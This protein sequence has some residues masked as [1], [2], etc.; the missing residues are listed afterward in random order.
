M[1]LVAAAAASEVVASF[2]VAGS[3]GRTAVVVAE[4]YS[5]TQRHSVY[6][7]LMGDLCYLES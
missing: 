2:A 4:N 7:N 3:A 5:E 1:R 6:E